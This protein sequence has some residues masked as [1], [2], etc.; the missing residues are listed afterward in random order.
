MTDELA[1]ALADVRRAYRLL[2][3]FQKRVTQYAAFIRERLG[4]ER[5]NVDYAFDKPGR[6]IEGCWTWDLLPFTLI[7]LEGVKRVAAVERYPNGAWQ[8]FPKR[9]DQLLYI[10]VVSDT[11]LYDAYYNGDREPDPTHFAPAQDTRSELHLAVVENRVDRREAANWHDVI[12]DQ[13]ETWPKHG[14]VLEDAGARVGLYG[15]VID[16]AEVPDQKTLA[17]RVDG[18][19]EAVKRHL[20]RSGK[21]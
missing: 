2:W 14:Q 10:H 3:A 1:H 7:G 21:A 13:I 18:F 9:G 6:S 8:N 17:A 16:L 11:A 5:Y 20:P 4:F 19:A 12:L 15:E